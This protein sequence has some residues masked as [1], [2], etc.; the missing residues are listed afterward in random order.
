M[1]A[2]NV[3]EKRTPL[4]IPLVPLPLMVNVPP[5]ARVPPIVK[6][7]LARAP[8]VNDTVPRLPEMR[9]P[10]FRPLTAINMDPERVSP[11]LVPDSVP[12]P[13]LKSI[14]LAAVARLVSAKHERRTTQAADF[15]EETPC[16]KVYGWQLLTLTAQ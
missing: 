10:P 9:P 6:E 7:P 11:A 13:L 4:G 15:I 14:V 8:V 3:P 12:P 16:G 2:E 5:A 1:G